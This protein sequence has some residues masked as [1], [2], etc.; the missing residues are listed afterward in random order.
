MFDRYA[1][2][3]AFHDELEKIS[4]M[5]M[6]MAMPAPGSGPKWKPLKTTQKSF[7]MSNKATQPTT[8]KPTQ[9]L[10]GVKPLKLNLPG[11]RA[12]TRSSSTNEKNLLSGKISNVTST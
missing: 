12:E 11:V 4:Q 7:G 3:E 2:I 10:K 1:A 6:G 9:G 5:G 8:L